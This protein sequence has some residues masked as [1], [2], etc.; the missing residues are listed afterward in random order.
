M[1]L[2]NKEFLR[3][4]SQKSLFYSS[5]HGSLLLLGS[6]LQGPPYGA[7]YGALPEGLFSAQSTWLLAPG[8]GWL[9]LGLGSAGLASASAFGWLLLGFRL[10]F[11]LGFGW[12]LASA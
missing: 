3:H 12:I 2:R 10:D 6:P 8:S 11:G 7:S 1:R 9:R 5:F 4:F